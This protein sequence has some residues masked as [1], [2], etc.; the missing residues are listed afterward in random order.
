ML[1]DIFGYFKDKLNDKILFSVWKTK[2]FKYIAYTGK[3]DYEIPVEVLTKFSNEIGIDELNR[4]K[5]YDFGN[6]LC[7][8]IAINRIETSK[9]ETIA[10]IK[11]LLPL[12]PFIL[13][14]K[15]NH[16]S[17]INNGTYNR[18]SKR[19]YRTSKFH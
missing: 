2:K 14:Q 6:A 11:N 5:E 16:C 18:I 17:T 12:L 15:G 19:N 10:D 13:S 8:S 9:T 3:Q 7:E 4:I 1:V